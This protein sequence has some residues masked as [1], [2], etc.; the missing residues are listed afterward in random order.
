MAIEVTVGP[1]QITINR[2]NTFVLSEPDGSVTA[3]SDQGFYCRD[4]RYVSNYDLYADGEHWVLQNS[5]AIAYYASRA[6]L[7]NPRIRTEYGEIEPS[8][9]SLVFTRAVN[10]GIVEDFEIRNY[11]MRRARFNFEIALRTDFA[12]IFEVKSKQIIRKGDVTTC[13]KL[14]SK[15][16]VSSY[17]HDGFSR[18]LISRFVESNSVPIYN[19]GRVSFGVDL[20]PGSVCRSVCE[21]SFIEGDTTANQCLCSLHVLRAR[22]NAVENELDDWKKSTTS[23]TSANEDVYRVFKQSVEDMAALRLREFGE[24]ASEFLRSRRTLVRCRLWARQL[25]C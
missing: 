20:E 4:T 3:R 18:S 24:S 12:D 7:I 19:N 13:W 14:D 10:D 5:G 21:H 9:L 22:Q 6:Y 8:S 1:P 17:E 15:Q 11:G 23:L 2:G 25:D 16:L